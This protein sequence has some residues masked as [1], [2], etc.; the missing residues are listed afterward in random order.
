MTA[1]TLSPL[2]NPAQLLV[3]ALAFLRIGGIVFALPVTG[4]PPTPVRAR[5]MLAL[6]L[7]MGLYGTLPK[8]FAPSLAI[9][10]LQIANCVVRELV[11]G[12]VIG[13][14]G[15]VA[16]DGLLMAANVVA[17]Q[18]GFGTAGLF[19]PDFGAQMDG[20]TAFHRMVIMLLFLTLGLH[21][22]FFAALVDTFRIIPAGHAGL[23]GS[24]G[25]VMIT[26]TAGIFAAALQLAAPILVALLFT[27]AAL[28]LV[29]RTVPQL[30]VFTMSFPLSFTIGLVIYIA[31][32]PFFPG[33][34]REHFLD[35]Q[36]GLAAA[37][38]GLA[39]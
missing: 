7:T 25:V 31:T 29:A 26:V 8:T 32:F 28:G 6:A 24:V 3:G 37:I 5:L 14:L 11:I 2:P 10:V 12:L 15:R 27:M 38:R 33:W 1:A 17:Y 35:V 18:M 9:D 23:N 20:F 34:M 16:F 4:D 21:Q 30:N 39:G 22:V 19:M 13:F 36:D